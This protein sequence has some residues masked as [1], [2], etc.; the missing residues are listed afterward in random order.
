MAAYLF[1]PWPTGTAAVHDG[2]RGA[3]ALCGGGQKRKAAH[4]LSARLPGILVL[5]EASDQTLQKGGYF[6]RIS[7]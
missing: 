1:V 3:A 7:S 5:L 4:L 2:E 6:I